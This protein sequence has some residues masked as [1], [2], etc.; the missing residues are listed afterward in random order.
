MKMQKRALHI[1]AEK[2]NQDLLKL[3]V[4]QYKVDL[5]A[6]DAEGHTAVDLVT[7]KK[8]NSVKTKNELLKTLGVAKVSRPAG[9]NAGGKSNKNKGKNKSKGSDARGFATTSQ[10]SS[11]TSATP[12][13]GVT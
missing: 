11:A 2:G 10:A 7:M 6:V 9:S 13:G 5:S 3:L 12:W 4:N 8:Y 1:V